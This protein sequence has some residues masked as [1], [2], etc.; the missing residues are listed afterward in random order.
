[1]LVSVCLILNTP[2]SLRDR[3]DING[4][5]PQEAWVVCFS[6]MFNLHHLLSILRV[7]QL[8]YATFPIMDPKPYVAT[9]HLVSTSSAGSHCDP[10]PLREDLCKPL[11]IIILDIA[12]AKGVD[13][14][15]RPMV[16]RC[17]HT[18]AFLLLK[19]YDREQTMEAL[20]VVGEEVALL[21]VLLD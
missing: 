20:V 1:M 15:S 3:M 17:W 18:G 11:S 8:Q 21:K 2:Q 7:L 5:P 10:H 9:R 19:D 16:E 14:I 12:S 6:H 4:V 13:C